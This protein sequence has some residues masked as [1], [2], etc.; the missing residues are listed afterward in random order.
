MNYQIQNRTVSGLKDRVEEIEEQLERDGPNLQM[1]NDFMKNGIG[2]NTPAQKDSSSK[3][4][5]GDY[6][7]K[8]ELNKLIDR[9]NGN[10][11]LIDGLI[12]QV[13]KLKAPQGGKV[14][15]PQFPKQSESNG[16]VV[17]AIKKLER[18]IGMKFFKHKTSNI[19]FYENRIFLNQYSFVSPKL[20]SFINPHVNRRFEEFRANCIVK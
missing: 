10:D 12:S 13:K 3:A 11:S 17:S 19:N 7:S 16:E 2:G 9:V 5:T 15:T 4:P 20:A 18:E 6:V 14:T 8:S 1:L